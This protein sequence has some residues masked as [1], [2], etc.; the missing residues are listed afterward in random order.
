MN[1]QKSQWK[2]KKQTF[3][4]EFLLLGLSQDAQTQ[5]LLFVLFFIIDVLTGNLLIFILILMYSQLHTPMYFSLRNISLQICL[6]NN[7]VPQALFHFLAKRKTL[8][9]WSWR[10][11][12]VIVTLQMG[13]TECALLAVMSCDQHWAVCKPLHYSAIITQQLC[14][15]LALG[16]SESGLLVSLI[17]YCCFP[18]SV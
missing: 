14:L 10:V 4:D 16:S 2:E 12:Q 6:S 17:K 5:I 15:Q 13:C 3:V 9:F 1:K 8:S 11:T 7:I 18:S